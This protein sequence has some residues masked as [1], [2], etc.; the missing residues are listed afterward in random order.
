V[1]TTGRASD[2]LAIVAVGPFDDPAAPTSL[3]ARCARLSLRWPDDRPVCCA[4]GALID[5]RALLSIRKRLPLAWSGEGP[6]QHDP[7]PSGIVERLADVA[8]VDEPR[9]QCCS[10]LDVAVPHGGVRGDG[11]RIRGAARSAGEREDV[12]LLE[13]C[14]IFPLDL[15][16]G[17]LVPSARIPDEALVPIAGDTPSLWDEARA[18]VSLR[19]GEGVAKA[20]DEGVAKLHAHRAHGLH[21]KTLK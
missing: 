5:G 15:V 19:F 16:D 8:F 18:R 11:C 6:R 3:D 4:R 12:W 17:A 13:G 10:A 7:A 21:L 1:V 14:A 20:I 2:G 9:V